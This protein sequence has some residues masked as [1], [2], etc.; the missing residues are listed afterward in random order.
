MIRINI[1]THRGDATG[2]YQIKSRI[3]INCIYVCTKSSCVNIIFHYIV[4][5]L[6]A[7][8]YIDRYFL[9]P[10]ITFIMFYYFLRDENGNRSTHSK[11]A[12]YVTVHSVSNLS[13]FV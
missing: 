5:S 12:Y 2:N 4:F 6:S 3:I 10:F 8:V 1:K 13:N 7:H 11:V 9:I